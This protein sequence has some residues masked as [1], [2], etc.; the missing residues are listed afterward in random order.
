MA[1]SMI[2]RMVAPSGLTSRSRE[3][4]YSAAALPPAG[5][6]CWANLRRQIYSALASRRGRSART[7]TFSVGSNPQRTP[8]SGWHASLGP[9]LLR[10]CPFKHLAGGAID[11]G[12]AEL[13]GAL[14]Q[15]A[16]DALAV[17]GIVRSGPGVLVQQAL[18]ERAVDEDRQLAGGGGDGFSLAHPVGQAAIESA[19][20]GLGA[21]EAQG[22]EAQDPRGPVGRGRGLGAQEPAAGDLVVGRQGE[23][24]R[25]VLLRGPAGHIGANLGE[26]AERAVGAEGVD[27]GEI[28]PGQLVQRRADV[29]ARRVVPRLR[30]RLR[31]RGGQRA[32]RGGAPGRPAWRRGPQ[33]PHRTRP[34][35]GDTCRRARGSV[36]ARRGARGGSGR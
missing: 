1:P 18:L 26:Q 7:A 34:A 13:G 15:A 14:T 32:G 25:E 19:E 6:R 5:I 16:N 36:A 30:L 11:E 28:D 24:G 29:E 27:L 4:Y 9:R 10:N 3:E 21:A 31:P 20:R 2:R 12:E 33:S 22:R 35:A 23:P 17:L 8:A